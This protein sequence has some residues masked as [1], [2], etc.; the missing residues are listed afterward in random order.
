[1]QQCCQRIRLCCKDRLPDPTFIC[2]K[3]DETWWK[4][5]TLTFKLRK[6]QRKLQER[7]NK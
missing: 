1:M 4:K 2:S 5:F 6:L 7:L 3:K